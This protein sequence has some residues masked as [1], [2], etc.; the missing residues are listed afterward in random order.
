[1]RSVSYGFTT[2]KHNVTK[3]MVTFAHGHEVTKSLDNVCRRRIKH[4][5]FYRLNFLLFYIEGETDLSD[6][7]EKPLSILGRWTM[8]STLLSTI[9][10]M[11]SES[12]TFSYSGMRYFYVLPSHAITDASPS[13]S[14]FIAF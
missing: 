10:I 13:R 11:C 4:T 5:T 7:S 14:H 12:S 1:M 2:T 6:P 8:V 9:K 3:K